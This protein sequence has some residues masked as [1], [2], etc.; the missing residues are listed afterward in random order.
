[1][2]TSSSIN[3]NQNRNEIIL[4]ALQLLGVIGAGDT[5]QA[6]DITFCSNMLNKMAKAWQA[7]GIHLWKETTASITI[8][9]D[10]YQYAVSPRPLNIISCRYHYSSGL[11]R[12]MKKLGRGEYDSLPNK[13]TSTGPSTCFY[14]SPQLATG[15]LYVWPVPTSSETS[16]T[17]AITYM[18][19]IE[20]FDSSTDEPD[21]PAEWLEAVTYNLAVRVAPAFGIALAT[22]NPDILS[23]AQNSLREVQT[24][25]SEEGSVRIT[26]NHRFGE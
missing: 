11:E 1:M 19:S 10:T 3:F 13:S 23:L 20:D 16:D 4:D 26:P 12:K 21:F 25:D 6:A 22:T 7:Q 24:W 15:Q 17:Y 14:Y 2:S 18:A 5:A 8:V 9:A